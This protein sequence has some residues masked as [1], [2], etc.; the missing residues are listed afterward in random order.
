MNENTGVSLNFQSPNISTVVYAVQNDKLSRH[1]VAQLRD[2]SAPWTPP[3]GAL[4]TIRYL[5]PDGTAGF[6]DTDED[7]NPAIVVSGSVATLTLAEQCT[8]VP[9]DVYMQL[10]FYGTDG[11]RLTSF[12]WLLRVQKSVLEDATIVSSDYYNVLTATL[13]QVA[14]DRA[15]VEAIAAQFTF[16]LGI[17]YGGTAATTASAARANIGLAISY[18]YASLGNNATKTL[19]FAERSNHGFVYISGA[20]SD[21]QAILAIDTASDGT[22]S[23]VKFVGG[24]KVDLSTS[25][26]TVSITNRSGAYVYMCYFGWYGETPVFS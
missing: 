26:K 5:K 24:T 19:T 11:E 20:A 14:A 9:G 17:P 16:P 21:A 23:A 8:T 4:P 13:A 6:Y 1:I 12:A 2:G 15:A 7:S 10:N 3:A 22:A 18:D 25:G